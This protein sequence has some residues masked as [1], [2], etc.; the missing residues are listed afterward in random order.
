MR[1]WILIRFSEQ[2]LSWLKTHRAELIAWIDWLRILF[3]VAL[4]LFVSNQVFNEQIKA[5][6]EKLL[7]RLKS[8]L[9]S[10]IQKSIERDDA[11]VKIQHAINEIITFVYLPSDLRSFPSDLLVM[12]QA[13]R[14]IYNE[15]EHGIPFLIERVIGLKLLGAFAG[16]LHGTAALFAFLGVLFMK[17]AK[18]FFDSP[19]FSG[20]SH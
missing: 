18:I 9:T 19:F 3:E 11:R 20:I 14:T 1:D 2:R 6:F 8:R 15:I 12:F 16:R 17:V 10:I 5:L 4:A 7:E 13:S